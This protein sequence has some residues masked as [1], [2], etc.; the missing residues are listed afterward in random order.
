MITTR[1]CKVDGKYYK[2]LIIELSENLITEFAQFPDYFY[3]MLGIADTLIDV[4][5]IKPIKKYL[6]SINSLLLNSILYL[7]YGK[8]DIN[9]FNYVYNRYL[10]L[11]EEII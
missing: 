7:K 8:I 9:E 3:G 5:Y 6:N 1:Y 4:F 11:L 2:N 10:N